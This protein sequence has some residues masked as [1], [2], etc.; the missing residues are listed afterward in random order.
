MLT[1][2][3]IL[4]DFA[5][6]ID[7]PQSLGVNIATRSPAGE[8]PLHW[9]ASLGDVPAIRLLVSNGADVSASDNL[10]NTALHEAVAQRHV[11]AVQ[12]LVALGA[13]VGLRNALGQ[14]PE[15]IARSSRHDAMLA[16]FAGA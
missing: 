8:S 16:V 5:E 7:R 15:D 10:G 11:P 3:E 12:E 1:L 13:N 6:Y 4:D 14:T 9:M 2:Q